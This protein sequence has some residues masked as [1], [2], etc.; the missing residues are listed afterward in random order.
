MAWIIT[1]C[2]KAILRGSSWSTT[3]SFMTAYPV[4]TTDT[5]WLQIPKGNSYSSR[6]TSSRMQVWS[7]TK[8]KVSVCLTTV[9]NKTVLG[10]NPHWTYTFSTIKLQVINHRRKALAYR[11]HR[12]TQ[13]LVGSSLLLLLRR[14]LKLIWSDLAQITRCTRVQTQKGSRISSKKTAATSSN[15]QSMKSQWSD[16]VSQLAMGTSQPTNHLQELFHQMV[17]QHQRC[18]WSTLAQNIKACH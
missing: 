9:C 18:K 8:L 13:V 7:I 17:N 15:P 4:K 2:L 11:C 6:R 1:R 5:W 12:E 14:N 3:Q 10:R 16:K